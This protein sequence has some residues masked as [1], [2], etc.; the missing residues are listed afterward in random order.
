MDDHLVALKSRMSPLKTI[1]V[2]LLSAAIRAYNVLWP[3]S[4]APAS[5]IE[6]SKCLMACEERM[7]DWRSSAA[8]VRADEALMYVMSWYEGLNLD[9]LKTLRD[10]SKWLTD[11]DHVQRRQELAHSM[12]QYA[13][14]HSFVAGERVPQ[15]EEIPVEGRA[16]QKTKKRPSMKKSKPTLRPS[17]PPSLLLRLQP[18]KQQP[19]LQ[20][21]L[22]RK[23]PRM[24]LPKLFRKNLIR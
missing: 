23:K 6:L 18:R 4:E 12:I 22:L 24:L 10:G 20:P 14:V 16:K 3:G 8:R 21:P 17:Q 15:P 7:D 2:E 5:V 1:G 11:P 19:R 9:A 13:P